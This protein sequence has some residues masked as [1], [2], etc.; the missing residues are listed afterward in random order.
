ME[1]KYSRSHKT[2]AQKIIIANYSIQNLINKGAE[3]FG[4]ER[5]SIRK[6]IQQ[7]PELTQMSVKSK[8]KT[9]HK[10]KNEDTK[11]IEDELVE[12][13]LMN[14]AL[15]I[16]VT[17]WEVIIKACKLDESLKL[18]NINTLQNWCYRFLK[19]NMLT[20]R[21]GTHI[22]QKLPQSYP[23]LMRKFTKFNEKLRSDNDF[24]L[25][26]IANM[27]ETPLF[28]NITNTKTIAKIGSKEVDIKTHEQEKIHVT[29]ILWIIADGTKLPPMLAFKGQPDGRV[30]RRL[31]KNWFVKDKKVFAYCQSKAWNN[32]TIMKKWINE[33]WRKYS[34]FIVKKET[35][36]VMDD[37][38]MHKIDIVKNKIKEC[39]TKIS[40]IPGGLARYLQPLDV[41]INKPFKDELKKKYTKYCMDQQDNKARVTQE[42]LINWVAEVWYDDKLSS[43]IISK[44]FK[45]A[46]ITLALDGSED[47]MFIGHNQ[48]LND[49]Q[50]MVEQ[51]EQPVDEQ[52]EEIKNT[53]I[54]DKSNNLEE[55][56]EEEKEAIDIE[57]TEQKIDTDNDENV[58]DF[59]WSD[60]KGE[61][62][63]DIAKAKLIE[64]LQKQADEEIFSQK[65]YWRI[66]W[67]LRYRSQR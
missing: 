25:N 43:E 22:G 12:W 36:L 10:G 24:E 39:N 67:L 62:E 2:V 30:E 3:K 37:A 51:V 63:E 53:E 6:W 60:V 45:A 66:V 15:G 52:D 21:S 49:D 31:N 13:I 47:E 41:S 61:D 11:D 54:D 38:S 35:M 59:R 29:T 19:R 4:V 18:K 14:R 57:F 17:S 46:G 50:V 16:A 5:K 23:E 9:L 34:Y 32:Q 42:D 40:M 58:I 27:D 55:N 8:T 20:F 65:S 33:V 64:S 26:Q 44:S 28:M 1:S 56:E 48:L 7:L